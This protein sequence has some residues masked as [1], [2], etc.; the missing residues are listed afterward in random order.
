M[1]WAKMQRVKD[2]F[3]SAEKFKN[4]GKF[5]DGLQAYYRA[6]RAGR[7]NSV[8]E[9]AACRGMGDCLLAL[10][11]YE[12]AEVVLRKAIKLDATN[13]ECHYFLGEALCKQRRFLE[14]L[15]PL[16]KAYSLLPNHPKILELLGWAVFMSGDANRG[17][18]FLEKALRFDPKD[19]QALCDLAVLEN[20]EGNSKKAKQYAS[21][22]LEVEPNDPLAQEVFDFVS[23]IARARL[24]FSRKVH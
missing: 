10:K 7:G 11:E 14:A 9:H 16:K 12:K 3:E 4:A 1:D 6:L 8:V 18:S 23:S 21:C 5:K 17:R 24:R 19:M 13:P 15:R 22:A 2:L 20:T